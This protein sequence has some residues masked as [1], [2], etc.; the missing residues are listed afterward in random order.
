MYMVP[1]RVA[2]IPAFL[3]RRGLCCLVAS[4]LGIAVLQA[5]ETFKQAVVTQAVN[6]VKIVA[7]LTH[8][9]LPASENGVVKA[10]D[11]VQTGPQS[12]CELKFNDGTVTRVGSNTSFSMEPASRGINLEQGSILFH[13]PAGMGGGRIQTAAATAAVTGTTIVVSATANGGFKVMALEGHCDVRVPGG[14]ATTIGPG[15][16]TFVLPGQTNPAPAMDFNLHQVVASSVLVNGFASPLASLGKI[17]VIALEKDKSGVDLG[18]SGGGL[19]SML[20]GVMGAADS[21]MD[22]LRARVVNVKGVATYDYLDSSNVQIVAPSS[23]P[24]GTIIRTG[25]DGEVLISPFPGDLTFIGPNSEARIT[26]IQQGNSIF[27]PQIQVD[28]DTGKMI[29]QTDSSFAGVTQVRTPQGIFTPQGGAFLTTFNNLIGT[30]TSMGGSFTSALQN[31]EGNVV[32]DGLMLGVQ[33]TGTGAVA[34]IGTMGVGSL[35][36][37]QTALIQMGELVSTATQDSTQQTTQQSFTTTQ[38]TIRDA[39][40]TDFIAPPNQVNAS[41]VSPVLP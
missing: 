3:M 29:T 19:L 9:A 40:L 15:Q 26:K 17:N 38:P 34:S 41:A 33:G 31:G 12:R 37:F 30:A 2:A 13:S 36:N 27:L 1:V 14:G 39:I 7:K 23:L 24:V 32:E 16:L 10:P 22:Q 35:L 20:G 8:T 25:A 11:I 6:D 5:E 21:N 18:N 28:L 4:M